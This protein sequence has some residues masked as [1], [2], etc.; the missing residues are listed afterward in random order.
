M[1]SPLQTPCT[2]TG[3]GPSGV[4]TLLLDSMGK[5]LLADQIEAVFPT[6][7]DA[8]G[9][10]DGLKNNGADQVKTFI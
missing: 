6:E 7:G 3:L 10:K 5:D 4:D 8:S 2:K 1:Y 9:T